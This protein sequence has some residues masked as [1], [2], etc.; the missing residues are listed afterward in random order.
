MTYP[1]VFII[2]GVA[3]LGWG[4][5]RQIQARGGRKKE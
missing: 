1:I 3:L 2:V 4:I 5:V